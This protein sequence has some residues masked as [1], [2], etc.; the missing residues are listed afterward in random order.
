M[1]LEDAIEVFVRGFAFQRSR[2]HPYQVERVEELWALRDAPRKSGDYRG[3]EYVAHGIPPADVDA[4]V[5][6]H[7]RGRYSISFI[8]AAGEPDSSIRAGFK[9]LGYRLGTTEPMMVHSLTAVPRVPESLPVE[10]VTTPKQADRLAKAQRSGPISPERLNAEPPLLRQ[11][12]AVDGE[13]PVGWVQSIPVCGGAWCSSMYVKPEYRR[14][15][16]GRSLLARMLRDDREAGMLANVLTA[17]HTGAKL[18]SSVGYYQIGELLW[19]T[20]H[21][22]YR[23]DPRDNTRAQAP[24]SSR[25]E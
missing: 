8:R 11:Y 4:I 22:K 9:D 13:V 5:R 20:P 18:Y 16:I 23:G 12:M 1:N 17:S 21:R 14:R 2:T 25:T 6:R 24:L 3:E 7:A 15:G 19:Y 10:R